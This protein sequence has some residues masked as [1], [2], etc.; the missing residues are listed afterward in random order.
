MIKTEKQKEWSTK[1]SGFKAS[2]K[3][4]EVWCEENNISLRQFNYW[5]GQE[6]QSTYIKKDSPQWLP[7]EIK[8]ENISKSTHLSIKIGSA[9]VEV[10]PGFDRNHLLDVLKILKSL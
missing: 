1:I 2:G 8:Q 4:K 9:K 10:H 7:V 3:T 5:L 6:N